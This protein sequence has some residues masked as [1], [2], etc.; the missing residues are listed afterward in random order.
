[1]HTYSK[2]CRCQTACKKLVK[3]DQ[4]VVVIV[5]DEALTRRGKV[6]GGAFE[7]HYPDQFPGRPVAECAALSVLTGTRVCEWEL[8][9]CY[10]PESFPGL[11]SRGRGR[12]GAPPPLAQDLRPGP[13]R[14]G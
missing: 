4:D 8:P 10:A 6:Y 12:R 14:G 7:Y 1:M 13:R 9:F 11:R 5:R 3:Q 2:K